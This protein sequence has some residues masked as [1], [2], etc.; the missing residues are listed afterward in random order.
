LNFQTYQ[1]VG[2]GHVRIRR[3][4]LDSRRLGV[5]APVVVKEVSLSRAARE[6]FSET[7]LGR[8]KHEA[9]MLSVASHEAVLKCYGLQEDEFG[10]VLIDYY[11]GS[12]AL[13]PQSLWPENH[14]S[15]LFLRM[16]LE[17]AAGDASSLV[18]SQNA[19]SCLRT[20]SAAM[21]HIHSL[22][23]VHRDIKP[24]N[25][26]CLSDGSFRL[27]DFDRA[28]FI[29]EVS[30]SKELI[31]TIEYLAPEV[32]GGQLHNKAA[33]VYAFA[34]TAYELLSGQPPFP[35]LLASGVPGSLSRP[36]FVSAIQGGLRP[37]SVEISQNCPRFITDP[38]PS[39]PG[40][41]S[42]SLS[43][44]LEECWADS[45]VS[46]PSFAEIS[47]RLDRLKGSSYYFPNFSRSTVSSPSL[48]NPLR[49][50][51]SYALEQG[52]GHEMEDAAFVVDLRNSHA[53]WA[54]GSVFD[55]HGG[56]VVSRHVADYLDD[57]LQR[58]CL[59]RRNPPLDAHALA[60]A[61]R[62]VN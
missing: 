30:H 58:A 39:L 24:S 23:I 26:F 51:S 45:P 4:V 2:N 37:G 59:E 20:V 52:R 7:A 25:V 27:G 8:I 36:E 62:K 9:H 53:H 41:Q 1:L 10:S 46:R 31:G 28:S 18:T 61:L 50:I 3:G 29:S 33:D 49:S 54:V 35:G 5:Q 21:N 16:V 57:W 56:N 55:G 19:L 60:E 14:E 38:F 48:L 34:V 47:E 17:L 42:S 11:H 40:P 6:P 22:D 43:S 12:E 15:E 13:A 32:L 44:L